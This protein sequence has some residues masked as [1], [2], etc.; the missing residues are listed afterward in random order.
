MVVVLVK[1]VK[2]EDRL[3]IF[4]PYLHIILIIFQPTYSSQMSLLFS[5][6]GKYDSV[7]FSLI[8][9]IP[10]IFNISFILF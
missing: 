1:M 3:L 5:W 10:L 8:T 6:Y 2:R 7:L 9:T 4:S